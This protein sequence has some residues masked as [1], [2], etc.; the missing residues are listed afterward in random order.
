MAVNDKQMSIRRYSRTERS[1]E[2]CVYAARISLCHCAI[3]CKL[4][5][6][7]SYTRASSCDGFTGP[8]SYTT[9]SIK[10]CL[11]APY[12]HTCDH[13]SFCKQFTCWRT[14]YCTTF[15]AIPVRKWYICDCCMADIHTS[16][17]TSSFASRPSISPAKQY[18]GSG[19]RR[20]LS[21]TFFGRAAN[22]A[23]KG[24]VR[25]TRVQR[26]NSS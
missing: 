11:S 4:D 14:P 19:I 25:R 10:M 6:M 12:I 22:V 3:V 9:P 18:I 5:S 21:G 23:T 20:S 13:L 8:H 24:V 26:A 15:F 17:A 2:V 16:R 7:G 1:E